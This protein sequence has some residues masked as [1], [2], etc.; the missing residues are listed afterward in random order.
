MA[1][2]APAA[3]ELQVRVLAAAIHPSDFG[4]LAGSY[5]RLRSLP[6]IAGREGIGVIEAL[7]SEEVDGWQVGQ[8]VRIP[9]TI[10]CWQSRLT[11]PAAQ[12]ER[13]PQGIRSEQA[14]L[15]FINPPCACC[16][17]KK[18]LP[19]KAG[20]W[21][22]QNAAG[23]SAVGIAVIQLAKALGF[24]TLN[25]VRRAEL[26]APLKTKG[27]RI[28]SS[29]KDRVGLELRLT[30]PKASPFGWRSTPVGGSSAIDQIKALAEGTHVT[31][32]AMTGESVRFPT[33]YLIFEHIQLQGFW[34]DQWRREQGSAAVNGVM[35]AIFQYIQSGQLKT[36]I[37]TKVCSGRYKAALA[38]AQARE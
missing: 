37:C 1:L 5:G 13:I 27:E 8:R 31:F 26:I 14:A 3:D 10:G 22:L 24:K 29:L 11:F 36:P 33:R 23:N 21:V 20:D 38:H 16:L 4:M 17:L 34:W 35:Q 7:G 9:D 18:I 2:K 30:T 25:T 32:G 6:A 15:A 28:R 19:L 12:A